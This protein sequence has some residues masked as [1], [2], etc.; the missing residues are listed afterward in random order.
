MSRKVPVV[1]LR[2]RVGLRRPDLF[3]AA[4]W[5][6]ATNAALI[7]ALA[8][9]DVDAAWLPPREIPHRLTTGD[10]VLSRLDVRPTLDGVEDGIWELCRAERR[11]VTVLN[12]GSS[13]LRSHDKLSTALALGSRG[14]RHPGTAQVS[15]GGQEPPLPF[16][17]VLKPRFGSWGTDVVLCRTRAEYDRHLAE[18]AGRPW[19]RAQGVLVQELVPPQG[20]DL[21][22]IVVCGRVVG[23]VERHAQPGEWRTNVALGARRRPAAPASDAIALAVEAAAAVGGDLVG[24]DLLPLPGGGYSVL[25]VNGAVDFTSEYS[26]EGRDVFADVAGALAAAVRPRAVSD[27]ATGIAAADPSFGVAL[28]G[29]A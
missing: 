14:V 13:M 9:H 15:G 20:Y 29:V 26:L 8:T 19:F 16:P 6:T 10:T 27:A 18:M 4:G 1:Q 5:L 2:R 28:D 11:G 17:V 25:E 7:R 21:R 24:I 23:S 22:L 3:V 12:A